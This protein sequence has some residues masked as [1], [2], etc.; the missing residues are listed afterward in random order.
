[1]IIRTSWSLTGPLKAS[2]SAQPEAQEQ[3]AV[4]ARR[5]EIDLGKYEPA[6]RQRSGRTATSKC[7]EVHGGGGPGSAD[8]I[9]SS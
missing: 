2:E 1:M 9:R 3:A 4:L 5:L 7:E 6:P 8:G